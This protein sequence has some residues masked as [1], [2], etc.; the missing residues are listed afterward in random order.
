LTKKGKNLSRKFEFTDDGLRSQPAQ[1]NVEPGVLHSHGISSVWQFVVACS[2]DRISALNSNVDFVHFNMLC[3]N[4][5]VTLSA[6]INVPT[7]K[8]AT[9][10]GDTFCELSV[11]DQDLVGSDDLIGSTRIDIENRWLNDKWKVKLVF[12]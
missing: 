10:P 2:N 11:M 7:N 3:N 9:I 8:Q 6:L 4:S 1:G 12:F 5:A